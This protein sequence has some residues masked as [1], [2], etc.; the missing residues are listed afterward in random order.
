MMQNE[1]R[2]IEFR[3]AGRRDRRAMHVI[4]VSGGM[5]TC[6]CNGVDW[7]S[8]IDA[9]LVA[10]ERHMVPEEDR[11]R[12]DAARRRLRGRI[13]APA[14]WQ[15]TWREDRVWRGLAPPRSGERERMI[16]DGRPTVCFIG[17]GT[18]GNREE[19]VD[20]AA[21]LGWRVVERPMGLTTLVVSSDTEGMTARGR[22]ARELGLPTIMP[23]QWDEW[24][25]DMTNA[26]MERIEHH[27]HEPTRREAH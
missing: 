10:G 18:A 14:D 1:E 19:Y 21:S 9:T 5:A 6:S 23:D 24:C 17:S 12:A 20:H 7:C 3:C 16:W 13:H 8:H 15:A 2:A 25:Y 26:I 4:S 27:G 11:A 22:D